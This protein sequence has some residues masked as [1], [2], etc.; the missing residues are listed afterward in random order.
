MQDGH[1]RNR[2]QSCRLRHVSHRGL[3]VSW[4][5]IFYVLTE[6]ESQQARQAIPFIALIAFIA[7]IV[8]IVSSSSS[9]HRLHLL[10]RSTH[11]H[12]GHASSQVLILGSRVAQQVLALLQRATSRCYG[13]GE[14]QQRSAKV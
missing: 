4:Y 11:L 7:F 9:S 2:W 3:V 13:L 8:F 1:A 14:L 10:Q 5:V 12:A 6:L